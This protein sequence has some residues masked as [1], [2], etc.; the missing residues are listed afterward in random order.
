MHE[1][2]KAH[3]TYV[4]YTCEFIDEMKGSTMY[5]THWV[6]GADPSPLQTA[7]RSLVID[8]LTG[9]HYF[10]RACVVTF[11]VIEHHCPC[12]RMSPNKRHEQ[13]SIPMT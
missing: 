13:E 8:S 2:H 3:K 10:L 9:C 11:P 12:S 6:S 7:R 1:M 5:V 4:M